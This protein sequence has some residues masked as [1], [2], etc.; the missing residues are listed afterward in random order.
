MA[1]HDLLRFN[2]RLKGELDNLFIIVAFGDLLGLPIM[3]PYYSLRLI[4]Y[5]VPQMESW[6]RRL[7]RERDFTDLIG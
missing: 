6:P 4:P 3:S 2:M 1:L 5:I 7:L